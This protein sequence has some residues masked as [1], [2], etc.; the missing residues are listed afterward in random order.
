MIVG[1]AATRDCGDHFLAI[2]R[3]MAHNREA[4]GGGHC[5]DQLRDFGN[6]GLPLSDRKTTSL[7]EFP[8]GRRA[9]FTGFGPWPCGP[10]PRTV[11]SGGVPQTLPGLR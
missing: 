6:C 2:G 1:D 11:F 8:I 7:T 3:R 4:A 5:A 9:G 10:K